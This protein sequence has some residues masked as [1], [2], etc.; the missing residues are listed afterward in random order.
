VP[1]LDSATRAIRE[2]SRDLTGR[3]AVRLAD[4]RE[5]PALEVQVLYLEAV[6]RFLAERHPDDADAR[7]VIGE[8]RR[9]LETLSSTRW[10]SSA[11]STGSRSSG[12][13]RPTGT[14]TTSARASERRDARPR[15]PR[16]V[17]GAWAASPARPAGTDG[18]AD[19][20]DGRAPGDA[21][22][23]EDQSAPPR[24]FP[25]AAKEQGRDVTVDWVHLKL[26]GEGSGRSCARTR[27]SGMM[28][29]S[30]GSSRR[31]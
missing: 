28:T 8:W 4:G 20:G 24:S 5:I 27:S 11:S 19:G 12:S 10:R 23:A 7:H 30:T 16:H 6:E 29:G 2:V 17:A 15:L 21:R 22:A 25:P 9:V 1:L 26:N 3:G 18:P 13:S 31:W 14:D